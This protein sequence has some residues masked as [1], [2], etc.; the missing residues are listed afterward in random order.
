MKLS[1]RLEKLKRQ[2]QTHQPKRPQP[3]PV[4]REGRKWTRWHWGLLALWLLLAAGGTWAVMELVVWNK[5]PPELVGRWQVKEGP[6]AGGAF[7]FFR[8]GTLEI[9]GVNQG[10]YYTLKGRVAVEGKNLLTTTQNP[11]SQQ[12]ETRKSV[13][14]ELTA[15][16][17]ILEL[18][19]GEVL[20]L[21]RQK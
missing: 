5:L 1:T 11:R 2:K 6:M 15:N 13:I 4:R 3:K 18:E 19:S 21:A 14:Q 20:K 7:H 12:D 10:R 8:Y 17:L 16:T 9:L